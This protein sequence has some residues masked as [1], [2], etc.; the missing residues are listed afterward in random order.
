MCTAL[1]APLGFM[2]TATGWY[3]ATRLICRMGSATL[4]ISTIQAQP[5]VITMTAAGEDRLQ[6][7]NYKYSGTFAATSPLSA[8]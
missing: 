3:G 1:V 7:N 5:E 2:R 4:C 8:V 6:K